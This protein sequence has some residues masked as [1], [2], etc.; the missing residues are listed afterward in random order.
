MRKQLIGVSAAALWVTLSEF[1]RNEIL[2]KHYWVDHYN[3]LGLKFETL[4]LNGLIWFFWSV[5]LAYLI[6]RLM[7]K[8]TQAETICLSWLAAFVMMWF[9]VFNLQV[10]PLGLLL[11]AIPLSLVEVA[12]A[13]A[14]VKRLCQL[15]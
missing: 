12:V 10:L 13:S 1:L 7:Q 9:T 5:G 14:I 4:P 8:F 3:Q 11:F 6:F 15:K 2:F